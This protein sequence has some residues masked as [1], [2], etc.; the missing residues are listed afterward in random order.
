MPQTQLLCVFYPPTRGVIWLP[1]T[2]VYSM[3][4]RY[5]PLGLD[6]AMHSIA[7]ECRCFAPDNNQPAR[8][9]PFR[10]AS[11]QAGKG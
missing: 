10:A 4:A 2:V 5:L 3:K 6:P 7:Q 11:L 9:V 1:N 8:M